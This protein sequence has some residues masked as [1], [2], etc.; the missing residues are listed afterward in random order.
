MAISIRARKW[1]VRLLKTV[2][3]ILIVITVGRIFPPAEIY[4]DYDLVSSV[5]DF[6][7]GDVNA[8]TM[9]DAYTNI[10]ILI[11]A[12]ISLFFYL[13]TVNLFNKIRK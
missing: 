11:I 7:Y 13:L 5:C 8:E 6:I 2:W 1:S 10:D 12:T 3:F 9:Y 4:L